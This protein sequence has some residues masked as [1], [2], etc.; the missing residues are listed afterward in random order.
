MQI[1]YNRNLEIPEKGS[2]NSGAVTQVRLLG[3]MNSRPCWKQQLN[4]H[5]VGHLALPTEL[6]NSPYLCKISLP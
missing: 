2:I 1:R 3:L 4:N 5:R 6:I